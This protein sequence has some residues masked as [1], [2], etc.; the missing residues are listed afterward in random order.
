MV[1]EYWTHDRITKLTR[2]WSE[3]YTFSQIAAELGDGCTRSM[4]AGK[5]RRLCFEPRSSNPPNINPFVSKRK[6]TRPSDASA[7]ATKFSL[8]RSCV[9]GFH[10]VEVPVDPGITFDPPTGTGIT[11]FDLTDTNCHWPIGNPQDEDFRFCGADANSP[12]P[13]CGFHARMAYVPPPQRRKQLPYYR[14]N[15]A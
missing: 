4:V 11:L 10:L 5:A 6:R 3:G 13:Y 9:T 12:R 1:I 2:C 7:I 14:P 8:Q 15:A